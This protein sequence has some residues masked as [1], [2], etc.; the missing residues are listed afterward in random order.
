MYIVGTWAYEKYNSGENFNYENIGGGFAEKAKG[1]FSS[2]G[3]DGYEGIGKDNP[4]M[5]GLMDDDNYDAEQ[6]SGKKKLQDSDEDD[7]I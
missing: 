7:D 5:P 1:Y 6:Q 2:P 3:A 4:K